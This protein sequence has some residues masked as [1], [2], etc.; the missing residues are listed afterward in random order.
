MLQVAA[1]A[2]GNLLGRRQRLDL[3]F[4][5]TQVRKASSLFLVF[6]AAAHREA[7]LFRWRT[8]DGAIGSRH[9]RSAARLLQHKL[10]DGTDPFYL[11]AMIVRQFRLLIQVKELAEAGLNPQRIAQTIK[12]HNFVAGKLFQQSHNFSLEQ[13]ESIYAHLLEID[14]GVKT[15]KTDMV[16]ALDL[17]VAG[18]TV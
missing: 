9:G 15:G 8:R 12:I 4:Q 10:D 3:Q 6:D 11:F 2:V 13:L 16:T 5:H 1:A 7:R 17:L 14:V 18:V